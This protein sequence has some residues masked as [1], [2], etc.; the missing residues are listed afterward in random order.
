MPLTDLPRIA[1]AL[2]K[3]ERHRRAERDD[4]R[5]RWD[6]W[7]EQ[8]CREPAFQSAMTQRR[9]VFETTNPTEEFSPPAEWHIAAMRDAGFARKLASSGGQA[10]PQSSPQSD[11]RMSST[12]HAA[13]CPAFRGSTSSG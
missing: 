4:R 11:R 13:T 9:A 3:I 5:A 6:A 10:R 8:A 7:W 12:E 1:P 2:A